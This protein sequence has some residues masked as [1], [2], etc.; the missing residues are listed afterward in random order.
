MLSDSEQKSKK[1][2]G[3]FGSFS[4]GSLCSVLELNHTLFLGGQFTPF[5]GGQFDRFFQHYSD[6]FSSFAENNE[7][8]EFL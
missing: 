4:G 1:R 2:R 5:L 7:I 3:Q 8:C 6:Q